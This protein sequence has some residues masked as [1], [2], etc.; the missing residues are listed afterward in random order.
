METL[1]NVFLKYRDK[2]CAKRCSVDYDREELVHYACSRWSDLTKDNI[3]LAY[4]LHG[5]GEVGL[6]DDE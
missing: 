4:H 1:V 6:H 3:V 2:I 5:P